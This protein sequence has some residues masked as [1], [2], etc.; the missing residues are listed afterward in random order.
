MSSRKFL[1]LNGTP[2]SLPTA[3]KLTQLNSL[4]NKKDADLVV[5]FVFRQYL[6]IHASRFKQ[7][8]AEVLYISVKKIFKKNF[9]E[10]VSLDRLHI[11]RYYR[12][13]HFY[14]YPTF[15]F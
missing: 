15:I 8:I 5:F 7:K 10:T 13:F 11:F 2:E 14:I 4:E 6:L 3:W 12:C 9:Q 1:K